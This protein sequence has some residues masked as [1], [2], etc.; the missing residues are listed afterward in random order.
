M[1]KIFD[2]KTVNL[3]EFA[4]SFGLYKQ[5]YIIMQKDKAEERQ[6]EKEK[7]LKEALAPKSKFEKA[8][9]IDAGI[10]E[11]ELQNKIKE[12]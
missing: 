5:L 12:N 11:Q 4:R 1:R 6:R 3:T 7:S 9:A 8:V 2:L 10:S